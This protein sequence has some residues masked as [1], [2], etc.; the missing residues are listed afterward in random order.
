MMRLIFFVAYAT[1]VLGLS[2]V[3]FTAAWNSKIQSAKQTIKKWIAA[4]VVE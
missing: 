1:E 4:G 2:T 3:K